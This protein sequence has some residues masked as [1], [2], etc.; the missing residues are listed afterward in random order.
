MLF[1]TARLTPLALLLTLGASTAE[2]LHEAAPNFPAGC[3]CDDVR[4]TGE[5]WPK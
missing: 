5:W 2:A 1:L 3:T 4:M